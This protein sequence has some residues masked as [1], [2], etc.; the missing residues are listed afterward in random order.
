MA[1]LLEARLA[2]RHLG[3]AVA[4]SL[5]DGAIA[6]QVSADRDAD[7]IVMSGP[8]SESVDA[9]YDALV[10][11]QRRPPE[12]LQ[13]GPTSIVV[14]GRNP[15]WG[16]V[17]ALAREGA[18]V[19][20]PATWQDG[21]ERYTVVVKSRAALDALLLALAPLGPVEVE[22]ATEVEASALSLTIPLAELLA[23]MT[24]KQLAALQLAI[25]SGYYD[26]PRG[27]TAE[28]LAQRMGIARTTFDEHLRKA[29]QRALHRLA[30]SLAAH[31]ALVSALRGR[32][33]PKQGG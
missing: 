27:T 10:S 18:T 8:T 25:A 21:V 13:R 17:S 12:V 15:E 14:R 2:I 4:E 16:V 11:T 33:R 5:R 20:W 3:C 28:A 19:L 6:T 9:F 1:R 29:E 7:I 24:Q 30:T 26:S 22:R 31:P 23:E 32:G